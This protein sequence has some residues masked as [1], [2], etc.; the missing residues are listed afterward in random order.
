M[1]I[2]VA[3]L[4]LVWPTPF[5]E[6]AKAQWSNNALPY[7]NFNWVG[8]DLTQYILYKDEQRTY[9]AEL[10]WRAEQLVGTRTGQCVKGVRNFLGLTKDQVSGDA[11]YFKTNS[12]EPSIG[13]II[14]FRFGHLGVIIGI[15]DTEITYYSPNGLGDERAIIETTDRFDNRIEGFWI[16]RGENLND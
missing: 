13:A 7:P 6:Q 16:E 9:E 11:I 10:R 14:K 15:S 4:P 1:A 12:R 2:V 8:V 5:I 3:L